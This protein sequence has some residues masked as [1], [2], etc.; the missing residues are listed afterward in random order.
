MGVVGAKEAAERI[1][2][3]EEMFLDRGRMMVVVV[4]ECRVT[5]TVVKG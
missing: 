4:D 2:A 3:D 5:T 1:A